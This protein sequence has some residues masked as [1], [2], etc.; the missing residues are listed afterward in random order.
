MTALDNVLRQSHRY[1]LQKNFFFQSFAKLTGKH[2]C[3]SLFLTLLWRKSVMH[4][5]FFE[6]IATS[7]PKSFYFK[8][9]NGNLKS[10][11][12][13][14]AKAKDI[15]NITV[16]LKS[17]AHDVSVSNIIVH[18]DNQQLNLKAIEVNNHLANFCKEMNLVVWNGLIWDKIYIFKKTFK[19][20]L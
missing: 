4:E 13:S 6:T 2:M 12:S 11:E 3:R 14:T 7:K 16:S 8:V 15:M 20:K 19:D 10:E 9:G 18:T 1:V 17:K 5:R